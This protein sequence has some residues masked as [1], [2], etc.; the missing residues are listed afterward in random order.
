ME[1]IKELIRPE[2]M[3]LIPVLYF[4]GLGLKKSSYFADK[5]IPV[6]LGVTSIV[7]ATIYIAATTPPASAVE[8]LNTLFAGITQG[9]LCAGCSVYANQLVKQTRKDDE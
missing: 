3:I 6:L 5:H 9:V 7:L 2:L 1:M 8:F 4:I